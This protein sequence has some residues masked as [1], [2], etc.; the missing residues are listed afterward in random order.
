MLCDA[1]ILRHD[2]RGPRFDPL[3]VHHE[4]PY[5]TWLFRIFAKSYSAV[6]GRTLPK[7]GSKRRG[8]SGTPFAPRQKVCAM[9]ERDSDLIMRGVLMIFAGA[10]VLATAPAVVA[11]Y[12]LAAVA[13]AGL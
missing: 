13:A 9:T 10:C 4:N 8:I 7:H 5:F 3:C 6:V 12:V 11:G 2:S 1:N